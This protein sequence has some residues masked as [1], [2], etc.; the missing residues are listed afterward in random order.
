MSCLLYSQKQWARK[1]LGLSSA[2]GI[3]ASNKTACI[4]LSHKPQEFIIL[5]SAP[6]ITH[7]HKDI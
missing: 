4:L 6:T 2:L 3:Y 5:I 7:T 1:C